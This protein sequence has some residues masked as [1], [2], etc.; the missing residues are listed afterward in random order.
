MVFRADPVDLR[1]YLLTRTK[2][3]AQ[4]PPALLV[5]RTPIPLRHEVILCDLDPGQRRTLI[6]IV[7]NQFRED[8]IGAEIV[9]ELAYECRNVNTALIHWLLHT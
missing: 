8:V 3:I 1:L 2:S 9:E 7:L 4:P 6:Q 5:H